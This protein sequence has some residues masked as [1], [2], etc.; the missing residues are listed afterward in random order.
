MRSAFQLGAAGIFIIGSRFKKQSSDT[1]KTYRH[2]PLREYETF[3]EYYQNLPYFTRIVGIEFGGKDIKDFCY[4]E[5]CSFLL[6][7]ESFGIPPNIIK[8]VIM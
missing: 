2:V 7:N 4:P 1:T 8:N 6:G 5:R 3:D